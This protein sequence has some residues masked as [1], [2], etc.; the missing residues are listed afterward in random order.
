MNV[1][2]EKYNKY[3]VMFFMRI[4]EQVID[5]IIQ[6]NDIVE[7]ISE[8]VSLKRVGKGY[9]GVCPFHNDKGPS[10]SV[11]PDKQLFHC[12]G[13]GAAGNV[14]GFIMRIRNLEFID[15]IKYLADRVNIPLDANSY[16]N[17]EVEK[18]YEINILAAR[19]FYSNLQQ[20]GDKVKYLLDRGLDI[21]TIKRFG[22][23]YSLNSYTS[24]LDYLKKKGY[25]E[26]L[27]L[28]AGLV[29]KGGKGYY[30]RFRNR[31]MFP[32]FDYKGRVIGFGGRVLDD[33]KPKYL[34][35]PETPVFKKG[36]NLYGLNFVLKNG[37]PNDLI[38]VEG[39]MDCIKLHQ[40]GVINTV[41]S[42]GTALTKEQAKLIKRYCN[43]VYLCYDSDAA[44]KAA[45][46]RGIEVL[47]SEGLDIKI[48]NIPK[49][50][51]PDEFINDYGVEEFKKLIQDALPA[52]E[53]LIMAAKSNKNLDNPRD[54][55]MFIKEVVDILRILNDEVEVQAYAAKAYELTGIAPHVIL[56]QLNIAR[57]MK[58]NNWNNSQYKRNNIIGGN[59][60]IEPGYKK[61]ERTLLMFCLKDEDIKQYIMQKINPDEFITPSYKKVAQLIY[62][63]EREINSILSK[64]EEKNDIQDVAK[65]FVD[66]E[67]EEVSFEFINGLIK[68]IK[69]YDLEKKIEDI[70]LQIK[71]LEKTDNF[72]EIIYLTKH[73][74]DL[75]RQLALL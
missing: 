23:G 57:K 75:K 18:I 12:F 35:S 63:G 45:T 6:K 49:G 16:K 71:R 25:N 32:V 67:I 34:N 3:Q 4:P 38:I 15:A 20:N 5:M 24:L 69:K 52:I 73:L 9:M 72:S 54:R 22:L 17:S 60:F 31:I 2:V 43:N 33:S 10:L 39:Y 66:E 37:V 70:K 19:Y 7:V 65:I 13:C 56:E 74:E 36:T 27:L 41:A 58:N 1:Y 44:G 62:S 61:A 64:F 8:Y 40:H 42:L 51:D 68:T 50:K 48:I 14:V 11:S 28:K 59:I 21:K 53:H 26:D 47:H 29:L 46:L 30:D 55:V